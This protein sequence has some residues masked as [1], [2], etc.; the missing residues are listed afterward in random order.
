MKKH[1]S[2][3]VFFYQIQVNKVQFGQ[4][5]NNIN[6]NKSCSKYL[7]YFFLVSGVN[8]A[9]VLTSSLFKMHS[10]VIKMNLQ[11][12]FSCASTT[13]IHIKL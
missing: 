8:E 6:F 13:E 1:T 7:I 12:Y 2:I 3:F 9:S 4:Y 10:H 5:Y 11:K